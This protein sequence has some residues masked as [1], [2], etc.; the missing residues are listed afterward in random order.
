MKTELPNK[1]LIFTDD[2]KCDL[3]GCFSLGGIFYPLKEKSVLKRR[4]SIK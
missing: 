4:K 1:K 3:R 2:K